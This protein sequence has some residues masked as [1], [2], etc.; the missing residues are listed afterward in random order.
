MVLKSSL[1]K[2]KLIPHVQEKFN[3][4]TAIN[5]FAHEQL[6]DV[7]D[8]EKS[9]SK[10]LVGVKDNIVTKDLPTSCASKML[11]DYV[12]PFDATVVELLKDEG[13]TIV[14]K[15]NMDE[16]GMGSGGIHSC[17]GPTYNPL[18]SKIPTITGGSSSGS[19]AAVAAGVVD[20]ALGTDTGGSV[21]LPAAYTST[22]GFKPSYGRLS[23]FGVI[24][25]AQSLDTVGIMSK[26]VKM[27]AKVFK[28]LDK[29]DSK[30]P[31]SM[32]PKMRVKVSGLTVPKDRLRI[33]IPIEL[34]QSNIDDCVK[35]AFYQIVDKIASLGHS[36][37]CVSIPKIKN[38]LSIYYAISSSEAASNLSRYDGI[39]YG[40]RDFS[41]DFLEDTL[42][43]PSRSSLG[44]EVQN[45]IVLGNYNL[46][47]TAY[48]N[49]F[50]KA[51][52]LRVE[53][54]D[55]FDKVFS[56]PNI[57]SENEPNSDGVDL[58]LSMTARTLPATVENFKKSEN[59]SPVNSYI[60]DI[61]TTPMS[62]AGLPCISIPVSGF[63]GVGIQLTGQFANDKC[64]LDTASQLT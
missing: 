14:G 16:F 43:A 11:K 26:E 47:S 42:F 50:L 9:L 24:A 7:K 5:S 51:Q 27:I 8:K 54:I 63:H 15:T 12:S 17:F 61:F 38:C 3:V 18:F 10:L 48:N 4:F 23:R 34:I 60:D 31:T 40:Y 21:R 25:Y 6:C 37:H 33:G 22:V 1:S 39:R 58:L 62:L 30:D 29:Y 53:L 49:N 32:D 55:E 64:V 46:S 13:A 20:F 45:R 36:V 41:Y 56:F 35:E 57:Y 2:L 28:I 44:K 59:I 52:K 19:A